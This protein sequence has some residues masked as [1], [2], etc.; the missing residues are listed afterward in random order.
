MTQ[1]QR[2]QEWINTQPLN[3]R[4]RNRP[5]VSYLLVRP[6]LSEYYKEPKLS[7]DL[8]SELVHTVGVVFPGEIG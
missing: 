3:I 4:C 8:P 6:Y 2:E 1:G 5:R 7:S